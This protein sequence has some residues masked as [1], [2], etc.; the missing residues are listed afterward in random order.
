MS[1]LHSHFVC[2]AE[3]KDTIELS[4]MSVTQMSLK[5]QLKDWF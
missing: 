4:S 1:L 5:K 2:Y 3:I